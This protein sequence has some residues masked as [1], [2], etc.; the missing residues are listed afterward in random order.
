MPVLAK[1]VRGVHR[2]DARPGARRGDVDA[3]E[4]PV[5]DDAPHERDVQHPRQLHVVDE[6]RAA[7]EQPGVFVAANAATDRL[8]SHRTSGGGIAVVGRGA[9]AR[10]DLHRVH[11]VLIPGA[12]AQVG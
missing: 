2:H 8:G 1:I 11:D 3:L 4:M 10:R 7:G 12:A 9:R 6:Q 5:R